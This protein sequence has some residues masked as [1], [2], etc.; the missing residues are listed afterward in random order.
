MWRNINDGA[1]QEEHL[2]GLLSLNFYF[3][4]CASFVYCALLKRQRWRRFLII[5]NLLAM[6]KGKKKTNC[7]IFDTI[8]MSLGL[9]SVS[10]LCLYSSLVTSIVNDWMKIIFYRFQKNSTQNSEQ[11]L[12]IRYSFLVF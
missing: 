3:P 8:F 12:S 1:S 11:R 4:K 7:F 9:D 2:F 5:F 10:N 6:T